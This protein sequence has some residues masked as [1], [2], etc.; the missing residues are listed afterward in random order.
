M[1]FNFGPFLELLEVRFK[2]A[3]GKDM[4]SHQAV[5]QH[6]H[7]DYT[8]HVRPQQQRCNRLQCRSQFAFRVAYFLDLLV[9]FC[10]LLQ[11]I[12]RVYQL[13]LQAYALSAK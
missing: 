9:H 5:G 1:H 4:T 12:E 2:P 3:E 6:A 11:P 8:Q 10:A 13:L 7:S